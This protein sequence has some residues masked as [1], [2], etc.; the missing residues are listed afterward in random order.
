MQPYFFPYLGYFQLL[1]TVDKLVVY[2]DVNFIKQGW[3]NRN[4]ILVNC[5]A[6]RIT[7]PV[8]NASS[9]ELISRTKLAAD[10]Q[11]KFLKTIQQAYCR[12]P[13]FDHIFSLVEKITAADHK[14]I[15]ELALASI[16]A[17]VDYLEFRLQV[18]STSSRYGNSH[19]K[20]KERVL[21]IC[22][23]EACAAYYNLP[24]GKELYDYE[25]FASAG[26][27]LIFIEPRVMPYKQL[28]CEFI[29]NLSIIDVLMFNSREAIRAHLKAD[30]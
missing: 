2:D 28:N 11:A 20:G 23:Q 21:D 25:T 30:A 26:I 22:R 6:Q 27:R 4:F 9:F 12:A 7:I 24:G 14:T 19:L 13:Y 8:R 5:K 10:W 1:A 18:E 16:Q 15:S 29:P 17:V 3:I